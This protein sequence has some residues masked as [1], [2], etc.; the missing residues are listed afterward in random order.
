MMIITHHQVQR[1]WK[2]RI[3]RVEAVLWNCFLFTTII[4][5]VLIVF[6]LKKDPLLPSEWLLHF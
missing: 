3:G 1:G 6:A 2:E 4:Y 5:N